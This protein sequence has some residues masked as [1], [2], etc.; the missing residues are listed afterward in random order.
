MTW[1]STDEARDGCEL[2]TLVHLPLSEGNGSKF[3]I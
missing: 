2:G 1:L 3:G